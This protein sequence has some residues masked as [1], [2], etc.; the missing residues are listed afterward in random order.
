V[1]VEFTVPPIWPKKAPETLSL[2]SPIKDLSVFN[3]QV[4]S[5]YLNKDVARLFRD[6]PLL[7]GVILI[8]EGKFLGMLS[9]RRFMEHMSRPY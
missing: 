3:F 9:R 1:S 4:E 6:Y 8:E 5:S 7:P 2:E